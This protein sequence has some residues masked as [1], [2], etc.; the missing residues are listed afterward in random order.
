MQLDAP[1]FPS[2]GPPH[3]LYTLSLTTKL[4]NTTQSDYALIRD[5]TPPSLS[6]LG[7][8]PPRPRAERHESHTRVTEGLQ[9]LLR[10]MVGI[11][12]T[13][14]DLTLDRGIVL[15]PEWRECGSFCKTFPW[16]VT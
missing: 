3:H 13:E 16:I 5:L 2:V 10:L 11:C 15:V 1:G 7:P 4:T 8:S 12:V 14:M 9:A 6:H